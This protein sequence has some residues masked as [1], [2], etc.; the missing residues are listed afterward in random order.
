MERKANESKRHSR[1]E[2]RLA[3]LFEIHMPLVVKAFCNERRKED[4]DC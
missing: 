4:T 2:K 1:K 3:L